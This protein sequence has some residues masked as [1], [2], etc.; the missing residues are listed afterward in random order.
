MENFKTRPCLFDDNI[1]VVQ[2]DGSEYDYYTHSKIC[3][4]GATIT[5]YDPEED[6]I[7]NVIV[8]NIP[9]IV[10]TD[11]PYFGEFVEAH[12]YAHTI[13][14]SANLLE[15][16]EVNTNQMDIEA[17]LF[18]SLLVPKFP[19]EHMMKL[20]RGVSYKPGMLNTIIESFCASRS[21]LRNK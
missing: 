1:E 10:K 21:Q 16:N 12:E 8:L 13:L 18:A 4:Y 2:L 6:E 9:N 17:D 15:L 7:L 14:H 19:I 20:L 11:V 5:H 3:E